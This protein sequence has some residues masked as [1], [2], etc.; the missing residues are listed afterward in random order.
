M[1]VHVSFHDDKRLK[2]ECTDRLKLEE[3]KMVMHGR[4]VVREQAILIPI[5]SSPKL[6]LWNKLQF[7]FA[8]GVLDLIKKIHAHVR[9]RIATVEKIRSQYGHD[10]HFDY[11][12]KGVYDGPL[13]HQKIMFNGIVYT[14]ACALLADPGT[15]KTAAYLWGIDKRIQRGQVKKALVITLSPLKENVLEEMAAQVPHLKGVVIKNNVQGKNIIN[16]SYK[17]A[18]NNKDYDVYIG[19]YE[20][21]YTMSEYIPDGYFDMVVLDE[22]HRA[23]TPTSRQ[24]KALIKAFDYVPYK[25]I[26]TATLHANHLMSFFSPFRFLG[27]DTVPYAHWMEFRRR[28]MYTVDKDGHIWKPSPGAIDECTKITG[29]LSFLFK[30]EECL[31]LPP[32]INEEVKCDMGT[33]QKKLY[34]EMKSDMVAIIED[35]CG[36]CNMQGNCDMSCRESVSAKNA[37][38][39]LTKLRQITCGFYIN[40]RI[41]VND[42]GSEVNDSNI[43]TLPEN[44]KLDLLMN[45]L[46]CIPSDRKV[47]IWSTYV[48]AIHMIRDRLRKAF[49]TDSTLTCVG[50]QDAYQMVQQFKNPEHSFMVAMM[51]KMGVGQNMQYSNYQAFFNNSY[52]SI[53]REQAL[54]R[55]HRQ[56]QEEKVTVFD[57]TMRKSID[58]IVLATLFKKKELAITLSRLSVVVQKGGFDPLMD[59]S[60]IPITD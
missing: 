45:V 56:G 1:T 44:P 4:A 50:D 42:D 16:K 18:K 23:G 47:I 20:S 35:M 11:D 54:G 28:F 12:Y 24:T 5:K 27:P 10:P 6:V 9:K 59:N 13:E 46:S 21:I 2:V 19:N 60:S 48:H 17:Q 32:M 3:M 14:D 40:T 55:Q 34:E 41:K 30:K 49:G 58:E 29:K 36:K 57:L 38:V 25:Y 31:D 33:N 8:P 22:A 53:Q 39:L 7:S 26:I 37:L 15:C 52:S 51:S 43:I